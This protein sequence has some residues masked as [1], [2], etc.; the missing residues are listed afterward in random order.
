MWKCDAIKFLEINSPFTAKKLNSRY[1][2]MIL[3]MVY[4]LMSAQN[5]FH[6]YHRFSKVSGFYLYA[7]KTE[8]LCIER[9]QPAPHSVEIEYGNQ[10]YN[11]FLS[12]RIMVCW[13]SHPKADQQSYNLNTK[14][15]I[16]K[17]ITQ[18]NMTPL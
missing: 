4:S 14:E 17:L 2:V 1:L 18:I 7:Q 11:I 13:I 3:Q 8:I 15:H 9:I 5:V 6:F 12:Q 16:N 10:T